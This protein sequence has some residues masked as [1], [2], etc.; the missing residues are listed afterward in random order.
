MAVASACAETR[1]DILWISLALLDLVVLAHE[2]VTN[3]KSSFSRSADSL[4]GRHL[5]K[6]WFSEPVHVNAQFV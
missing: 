6:I 2:N 5:V 3:H 1:L 4:S